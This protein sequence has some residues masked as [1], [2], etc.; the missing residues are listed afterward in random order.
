M[1]AGG[2]NLGGEQS[3]H[4]VMTDYATTG[5][6]LIAG[7][8]FLAAMVRSGKPAS[9]LTHVFDTVPQMLKN[10]RFSAGQTPLE[11]ENVVKVIAGAEVVS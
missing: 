7:I 2:Y 9:A 4:I 3:G 11:A 8:Q 5:D 1:R 10:V 6:G